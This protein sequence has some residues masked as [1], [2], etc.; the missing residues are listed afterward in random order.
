[1]CERYAYLYFATGR[2]SLGLG[3]LW[4][5]LVCAVIRLVTRCEF[6]HVMV[7]YDGAV[8]NR[9]HAGT[10]FWAEL[11][12]LD[13]SPS[14]ACRFAVPVN[15]DLDLDALATRRGVGILPCVVRWFT[16]G[17]YD[18]DDCI[19]TATLALAQGDVHVPRN[20]GSAADLWDWLR[21]QGYALTLCG[22]AAGVLGGDVAR[23]GEEVPVA[24]S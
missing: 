21:A 1:M 14:T 8:L 17:R 23:R 16:G 13:H 7:A 9:G 20:I 15:A 3:N 19:H 24:G 2:V 12:L 4:L 22:P 5:S 18:A 6:V 11:E 10:Q